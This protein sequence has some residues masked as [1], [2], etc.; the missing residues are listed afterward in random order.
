[1]KKKT[2]MMRLAAC[3]LAAVMLG[4]CGGGGNA[5][6]SESTGQGGTGS[7]GGRQ[8]G[9]VN[10]DLVYREE[11]VT[12]SDSSIRMDELSR[13]VFKDGRVYSA[14]NHYEEMPLGP[15]GEMPEGG[16]M[17]PEGEMPEGG[18]AP[19]EGE[20]PPGDG[21]PPEDPAEVVGHSVFYRIDFSPE[22]GDVN[23]IV[24]DDNVTDYYYGSEC[25]DNEYNMYTVK[26]IYG[27][28]TGEDDVL[29]YEMLNSSGA[30]G[31]AMMMPAGGGEP[32]SDTG[33]MEDELPAP[34]E[35][36]VTE[37]E[38]REVTEETEETGTGE[39]GME[40]PVWD[41][42]GPAA[43][44][45]FL[46]KY[47]AEGNVVFETQM[48]P[49]AN[50][51][52]YSIGSMVHVE[53][54]GVLVSSNT[55]IDLYSEED[56]SFIKTVYETDQWP[57]MLVNGKGEVFI[58]GFEQGGIR[59]QQFDPE[60]GEMDAGEML[61]DR[62]WMYDIYSMKP[63]L[64][65]DFL[66][67]DES[68]IYTWN[69]GDD[70]PERI[71]SYID[72]DLDINYINNYVQLSE[73]EFFL[74]YFR[75]SETMDAP[76]TVVCSR[77]T[78]VPP[79]EVADKTVLTL[80]TNWISSEVRREVV[81]F[82]RTNDTYRISVIDYSKYIT[83]GNW[84]AG[85]AQMNQDIISGNAPDL[86]ILESAVQ[87][88]SYEA[89]GILE[90]LDEYFANDPEISLDNYMTNVF[91]AYR[92][93]DKLYMV[94]PTFS[95]RSYVMK[96]KFADSI[97]RWDYETLT[98]MVNDMG[99]KYDELFG[100]PMS[101]EDFVQMAILLDVQSFVDW[102]EQ[103]AKFDT[104]EFID[105]LNF[106]GNFPSRDQIPDNWW[107]EGDRETYFRND[108]S[109]LTQAYYDSFEEYAQMRYGVFG[110]E[111]AFI[112]FPREGG[113]G[114]S[115]V[116]AGM[117]LAM[118]AKAKDKD[119]CWQFMR[120]FLLDEY[121]DR[122]I[123]SYGLPVGKKQLEAKAERAMERQFWIN[124]AT[125][126]KVYY[127]NTYYLGGEEITIP[128]LTQEDV[129]QCMAL[130]ESLD[131]PYSYNEKMMEMVMEEITPFFKGQK[132]AEEVARIIQSK[133][134]VYIDENS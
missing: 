125:G 19:A 109:I 79:E 111:V 69:V 68:G 66:L 129:D 49:P 43:E 10:K 87:I 75:E 56:G 80:G 65:S 86:M 22:G 77:L 2:T 5:G 23:R 28:R 3:L 64:S 67:T 102:G 11:E 123:G 70:A 113:E 29:F 34:A 110:E 98:R 12:F 104:K 117:Q 97:D 90:P 15:E 118:N 38:T 88:E 103:R 89:K 25:F 60:K 35:E 24:L 82:N 55:G 13:P 7:G 81:N 9:T 54:V 91:D 41:D 59:M 4:A 83:E 37:E 39:P 100:W 27:E 1:M 45:Y 127:D 20:I 85:Y 53:D 96:K 76:S 30:G 61:P 106:A 122:Y 72:S 92:Y 128:P 112:G 130:F 16:E 17:P 101:N 21:M 57:D 14:G 99:L 124:E 73:T 78:K 133:M 107:E 18:E 6:S 52:F 126:E 94:I 36:E 42:M 114:G 63:G 47:D 51:D 115:T 44:Q 46:M 132:S 26:T 32:P 62:M 134:Q 74:F 105:L 40:M 33:E 121:Q 116:M 93:R 119:A 131:A 84:D 58:M 95:A 8:E 48:Q 71:V 31:G 108:R 120:R 50:A